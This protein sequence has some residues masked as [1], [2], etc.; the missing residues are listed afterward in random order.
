[1]ESTIAFEAKKRE[2]ILKIFEEWDV[3]ICDLGFSENLCLGSLLP[4]SWQ[5]W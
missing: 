3:E 5:A 1:M 4:R 2:V